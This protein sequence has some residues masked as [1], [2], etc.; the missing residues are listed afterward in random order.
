MTVLVSP[1]STQSWSTVKDPT[2]ATVKRPT[3]LILRVMPRPRPDMTSQ[4]HQLGWKALVGPSSCWFVKERKDRAVKAVARTKGE[5][6]R[7]RRAWVRRPF[8]AK[9]SVSAVVGQDVI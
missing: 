9:M 7:I 6:R 3:H 2:Q 5:S 4:N 8:S 1:S